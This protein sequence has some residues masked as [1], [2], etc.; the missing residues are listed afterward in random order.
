MNKAQ[1]SIN[2]W[3]ISPLYPIYKALRRFFWKP[4]LH[5][6]DNCSLRVTQYSTSP[7]LHPSFNIFQ[8]SWCLINIWA[9]TTIFRP[10]IIC[11][12]IYLLYLTIIRWSLSDP[13]TQVK[14]QLQPSPNMQGN[15]IITSDMPHND[16][17]SFTWPQI[18]LRRSETAPD[19]SRPPCPFQGHS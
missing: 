17:K 9:S 5:L 11:K 1:N 14:Q 15:H 16:C 19:T 7:T 3:Y 4:S 13:P 18:R 12:S 6:E 2:L 8:V 10:K